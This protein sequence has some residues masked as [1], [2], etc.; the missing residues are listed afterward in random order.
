VTIGTAV[1]TGASVPSAGALVAVGSGST[2]GAGAGLALPG[3]VV[4]AIRPKAT[5]NVVAPTP[6]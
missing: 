1:G 6:A 2:I 4:A 3:A 5:V